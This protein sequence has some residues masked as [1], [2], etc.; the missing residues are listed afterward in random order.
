[1][2][3]TDLSDGQLYHY[4]AERKTIKWTKK[5]CWSLFGRAC[6]NAYIV[7]LK[8]ET[9]TT[10]MSRLQFMTMAIESFVVDYDHQPILRH[11]RSNA[12]ILRDRQNVL[13]VQPRRQSDN[14]WD[15]LGEHTLDKLPEKKRRDCVHGHGNQ[16]K[17]SRYVCKK[18]DVG[19]CPECF[20]PYHKRPRY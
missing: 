13:T 2:G 5:V 10:K 12:E 1:M 4:L 17:R 20:A 11:R 15:I 7:Y 6:L 19:L 18:C 8:S 16:R 3:G 14:P 9:N